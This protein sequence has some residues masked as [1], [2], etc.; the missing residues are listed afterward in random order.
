MVA[1]PSTNVSSRVIAPGTT[2]R[3]CV[4]RSPCASIWG[5]CGHSCALRLPCAHISSWCGPRPRAHAKAEA[6]GVGVADGESITRYGGNVVDDLHACS[7]M[8]IHAHTLTPLILRGLRPC[9]ATIQTLEHMPRRRSTCMHACQCASITFWMRA[10]SGS[11]VA[12]KRQIAHARIKTPNR[13]GMGEARPGS[14]AR[15]DKVSIALQG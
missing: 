11:G 15:Q 14:C 6:V 9:S 7:C 4:L 13:P 1:D 10:S 5:A 3:P 8:R 2:G 12:W